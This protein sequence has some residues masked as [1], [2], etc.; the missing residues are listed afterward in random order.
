MPRDYVAEILDKRT[1][2]HLSGPRW[3]RFNRR[4]MP[5]MHASV[6]LANTKALT[7]KTKAEL[8]RYF[9]VAMVAALEGFFRMI[10]A[11]LINTGEPYSGRAQGFRDLKFGAG[12][13]VAVQ[14]KKISAGELI[15]H[16]LPHNS[17]ANVEANMSVLLGKTFRSAITIDGI[18]PFAALAR[19]KNFFASMASDLAE[20]FR[21]R[22][23]FCHELA[24]KVTLSPARAYQL[25][26]AGVLLAIMTDMLM[27]E[28]LD[29]GKPFPV[30]KG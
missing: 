6:E 13:I 24:T 26:Q 12:P 27:M 3:E 10:Y 11:D 19:G 14:G 16:Q 28:L 23:V 8:F 4:I 22:H 29:K 2:V 20:M 30:I 15:A 18:A 7:A 5:I 1:R 9:P 25:C 17:F 21:V